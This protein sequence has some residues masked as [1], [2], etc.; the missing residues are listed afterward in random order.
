MT[1]TERIAAKRKER[2]ALEAEHA[3]FGETYRIAADEMNKRMQ[4]I[5]AVDGAI[6]ELEAMA[7]EAQPENRA[8]RRQVK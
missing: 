6:A 7:V 8:K 3:K 1:I 2:A 4:R 5:I